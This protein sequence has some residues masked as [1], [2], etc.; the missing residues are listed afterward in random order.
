MRDQ[1][2]PTFARAL[3]AL[4]ETFNEPVS[5][6]RA[7][8]YFDALSDLP[9]E[10]VLAAARQAI[11]TARFFPRPVELREAVDGQVEDRAEA[12]WTAVLRLVRRYGWPGVDGRGA[13]P[14]FPDFATER[15][16]LDLYGGWARLCEALP[17]EG[18]EMLGVRKAFVASFTAYA[19][20][21]YRA[22]LP[23]SRAEARAVLENLTAELK[24]RSLPTGGM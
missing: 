19:R 14:A 7:E 11:R 12:A 8:A 21:G 20:R 5:E 22:E 6:I 3:Y 13:P 23:P 10:A 1:D 15:A 24:R 18:P 17:G 2:R 9:V 16:A 4:G